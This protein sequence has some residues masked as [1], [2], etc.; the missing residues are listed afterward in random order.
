[1]AFWLFWTAIA[2]L[3]YTYLLFPLLVFL[4]GWL[5][6]RPARLAPLTPQVSVII[7]A[8]NEAPAIGAKVENMLALDYPPAQLEIIVASDGSDDGTN[9]IVQRYTADRVKLLALPRVGKATALNVAV[10]VATGDILV[11]SDANSMY[12]ADSLQ[13]LV[14]PFADPQVGGV[15]GNQRYLSDR[16]GG[17]AGGG[18]KSYWQIDRLLKTYESLGGNTISATGAIYAIRRALFRPIPAGVTDD[19][20]NSTGVIAQGYR[21]IFAPQAVAFELVAGSGRREYSRKVRVITRGLRA[22]SLRR[23]L[24]NPF[25][26][27]FYS[28]QLFS[29]KVL[30]RLAVF[31][32]LAL[33][34][35]APRL[36]SRG[37]L[38][39]LATLGQAGFYGLAF[40]GWLLRR[41]DHGRQKLLALPYYFVLVN[42]ACLQ[43][44]SNIVR[45][46][47]IDRWETRR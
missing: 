28:L 16:G 34:V 47:R 6:P 32:L 23:E 36:W 5:F 42:A 35:S 39:R 29:H 1:M 44:V 14:A 38:Y 25:R 11:F 12:A 10:A 18:E 17:A 4:R 40:L 9:E 22:V 24:L 7:A 13:H 3:L 33:L 2:T 20:A 30:R 46:R 45:G 43:A 8:H 15:A 21:L 26:F 31:P 27:G 19:F 37:L 41:T